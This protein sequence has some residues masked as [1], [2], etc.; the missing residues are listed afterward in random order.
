VF[1][2]F[3]LIVFLLTPRSDRGN[4]LPFLLGMMMSSGNGRYRGRYGDGFGGSYG[5]R[6]LV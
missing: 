5:G 4:F 2:L 3:L 6:W 1:G